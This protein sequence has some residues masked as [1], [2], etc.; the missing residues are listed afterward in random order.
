MIF[1]TALERK[2][3]IRANRE[4]LVQKGILLPESPINLGEEYI[5]ILFEGRYSKAGAYRVVL[6]TTHSPKIG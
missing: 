3:S 1:S 6:K 2:I 5:I 4:I